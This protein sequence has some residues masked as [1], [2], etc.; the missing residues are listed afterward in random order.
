MHLTVSDFNMLGNNLK[1]C[2]VKIEIL[3]TNCYCYITMPVGVTY[4]IVLNMLDNYN[5]G[6]TDE[7]N[8]F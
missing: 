4:K 1:M 2:L 5:V 3:S 6:S 7:R 8:Y